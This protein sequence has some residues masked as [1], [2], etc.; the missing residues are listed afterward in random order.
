MAKEQ[1]GI[2]TTEVGGPFDVVVAG[3]RTYP[4]E[5][6]KGIIKFLYKAAGVIR[7]DGEVLAVTATIPPGMH[8]HVGSGSCVLGTETLSQYFNIAPGFNLNIAAAHASLER[9][10]RVGVHLDVDTRLVGIVALNGANAAVGAAVALALP[11]AQDSSEYFLEVCQI[12]VSP[13]VTTITTDKITDTRSYTQTTT[14]SDVVVGIYQWVKGN[15]YTRGTIILGSNQILYQALI[16][17]TGVD[18]TT[19]HTSSTWREVIQLEHFT[20]TLISSNKKDVEGGSDA[21]MAFLDAGGAD[22]VGPYNLVASI[23]V[24]DTLGTAF[25]AVNVP[26]GS[27][28]FVQPFDNISSGGVRGGSIISLAAGRGENAP[29]PGQGPDKLVVFRVLSKTKHNGYFTLGVRLAQGEG[30]ITNAN[31]PWKLTAYLPDEF[32]DARDLVGLGLDNDTAF[33][34]AN[35][36]I[37]VRVF[38]PGGSPTIKHINAKVLELLARPYGIKT[39]TPLAGYRRNDPLAVAGDVALVQNHVWDIR[40]LNHS[41][42]EAA[43]A[44]ME[45]GTFLQFRK[46]EATYVQGIVRTFVEQHAANF[47]FRVT[48]DSTTR[49]SLGTINNGDRLNIISKPAQVGWDDFKDNNS[50]SRY[51]PINA[52]NLV[53]FIPR[54]TFRVRRILLLTGPPSGINNIPNTPFPAGVSSAYTGGGTDSYRRLNLDLDTLSGGAFAAEIESSDGSKKARGS[55]Y[56]NYAAD[57]GK[58]TDNSGISIYPLSNSGSNI[59]LRTQKKPRSGNYSEGELEA[60]D[61]LYLVEYYTS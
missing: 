57:F 37:L 5:L 35:G 9:I 10:V 14:A 51:Q 38:P 52:L 17:N 60:G 18:P 30:S 32:L 3:D 45:P 33:A 13:G 39:R 11:Y 8:V 6:Q 21:R 50:V 12:L 20:G 25:N 24:S 41:H 55:I 16:D 29:S 58:S 56:T 48:L 54:P 2:R 44:S 15:N 53:R 34:I 42:R 19:D 23:K 7:D 59:Q 28:N 49:E 61:K 40:F 46:D 1:G 4:A 27:Q 22:T 31:L 43:I 47:I 26:T 36:Q